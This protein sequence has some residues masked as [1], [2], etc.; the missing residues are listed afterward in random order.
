MQK[1]IDIPQTVKAISITKADQKRYYTTHINGKQSVFSFTNTASANECVKFLNR[2]RQRYSGFPTI[3]MDRYIPSPNNQNKKIKDNILHL[4]LRISTEHTE[5]LIE[6]CGMS[7]LGLILISSFDF[8]E[9]P[10]NINCNF[11]GESVPIYSEPVYSLDSLNE[12]LNI[13]N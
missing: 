3:N 7:G 12:L 5:T 1:L 8:I 13:D 2:Y 9:Y 6:K 11:T 4:S 10:D